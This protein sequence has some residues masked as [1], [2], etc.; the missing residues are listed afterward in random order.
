MIVTETSSCQA[1]ANL[2]TI[3]AGARAYEVTVELNREMTCVEV[4]A[5]KYFVALETAGTN[6]QEPL[7]ISAG[8]FATR[9]NSADAAIGV[10]LR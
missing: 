10:A 6:G 4:P 3:G 7:S 5:V 2:V 8:I 9:T 1:P